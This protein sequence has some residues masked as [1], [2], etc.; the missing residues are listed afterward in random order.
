MP[1]ETS[2]RVRECLRKPV[3]ELGS[4]RTTAGF[5]GVEGIQVEFLRS[6]GRKT[7]RSEITDGNSSFDKTELNVA[8]NVWRTTATGDRQV[9]TALC[10]SQLKIYLR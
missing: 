7:A 3:T 6:E 4:T 8:R 5:Q 9:I 10:G 2:D 1:A